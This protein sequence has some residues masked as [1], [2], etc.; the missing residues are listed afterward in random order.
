MCHKITKL[1][2][3]EKKIYINHANS[4]SNL[5]V[6]YIKLAHNMNQTRR[7]VLE[8]PVENPFLSFIPYSVEKV[9]YGLWSWF[10]ELQN[11]IPCPLVPETFRATL[12]QKATF[13]RVKQGNTYTDKSFCWDNETKS[14]FFLICIDVLRPLSKV[15][16]G[17]F[18]QTAKLRQ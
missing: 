5:Y 18:G 1:I 4:T 9:F 11:I 10:F 8:N 12:C 14:I 2:S 7:L 13:I 16:S 6:L 3:Y 17:I 15:K